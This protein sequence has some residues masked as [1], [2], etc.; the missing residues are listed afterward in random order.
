MQQT[1]ILNPFQIHHVSNY[2]KYKITIKDH[3]YPLWLT[4]P[5]RL[6]TELY[7]DIH[8]YF[9]VSPFILSVLDNVS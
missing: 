9:Q 3:T 5:L 1:L 4:I 6:I 2:K 8:P 7:R